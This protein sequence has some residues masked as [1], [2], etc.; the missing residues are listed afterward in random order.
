LQGELVANE[1]LKPSWKEN[2]KIYKRTI[3]LPLGC[4]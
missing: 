2:M 1:K 3:N 4:Q